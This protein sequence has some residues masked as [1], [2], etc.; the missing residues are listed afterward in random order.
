MCS[1]YSNRASVDELRSLFSVAAER[2]RLG[3]YAAQPAI[4]PDTA[5]PVLRL[6]TRFTSGAVHV[7]P[8]PGDPGGA[9]D[10]V[11]PWS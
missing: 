10:R 3:N 1:L 11:G 2:D 5:A 9:G 7:R 4:F 6:G 8:G